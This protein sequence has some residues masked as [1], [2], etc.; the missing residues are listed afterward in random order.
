MFNKK[1]LVLIVGCCCITFLSGCAQ[2]FC[3]YS[4]EEKNESY[5]N[6]CPVKFHI[7]SI[8]GIFTDPAEM[9]IVKEN[10]ISKYPA[11]F[12]SDKNKGVNINFFWNIDYQH[13]STGTAFLSGLTFG[14]I[15]CITANEHYGTLVAR[16]IKSRTFSHNLMNRAEGVSFNVKGTQIIHMPTLAILTDPIAA[17]FISGASDLTTPYFSSIQ[18][19][20]RTP[21][22]SC[23]ANLR[24]F[25]LACIKFYDRLSSEEKQILE[26]KYNPKEINL[27]T[28]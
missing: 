25:P 12:V 8:S 9:E 24:L 28:E 4:I 22:K 2:I 26:D 6:P 27:L 1:T 14:I 18:E 15:P 21:F 5:S 13:G 11:F 17:M 3:G 20:L 7:A 10:L 19:S 16:N 23:D